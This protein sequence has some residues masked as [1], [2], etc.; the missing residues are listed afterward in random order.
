MGVELTH[1]LFSRTDSMLE[2]LIAYALSTGEPWQYAD[3]FKVQSV[4]MLM[5]VHAFHRSCHLVMAHFRLPCAMILIFAIV[6]RAVA[7]SFTS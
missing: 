1:E 2:L 5:L 3:V 7:V 6:A 4:G